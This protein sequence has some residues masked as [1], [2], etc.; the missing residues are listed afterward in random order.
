LL[1]HSLPL[2]TPPPQ[3]LVTLPAM[4]ASAGSIPCCS[5]ALGQ[6][7]QADLILK[8][9]RRVQDTDP[10]QV[11]CQLALPLD[12]PSTPEDDSACSHSSAVFAEQKAGQ[13]KLS[14]LFT[15]D[16]KELESLDIDEAQQAL[17]KPEA[18]PTHHFRSGAV[19][20][21]QWRG[22][23]RHGFGI[24]SW[25]DG[26]R[27]EGEWVDNMA[28]GR[29]RITFANGDVY[30]G[31]WHCGSFHGMGTYRASDGTKYVGEWSEDQR[32]GH[33][34][35]ITREGVK[36][37]GHFSAGYKEGRGICLW[38]DG[39][40]YCGNWSADMINGLGVHRNARG[41]VFRGRWLHAARHGIGCHVWND[42]RCYMGTYENNRE[43]GFGCYLNE[44]GVECTV[45]YW[46]GGLF[47]RQ[48][49]LTTDLHL[50]PA[51]VHLA[52][53]QPEPTTPGSDEV[54]LKRS[55]SWS[56]DGTLEMRSSGDKREKRRVSFGFVDKF[57][58]A[59]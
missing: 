17:E 52:A 43:A 12:N 8:I 23:A 28:E 41:G 3:A 54:V 20:T 51:L 5:T 32:H 55:Y 47:L 13:W 53:L 18:R 22:K 45:G 14:R 39:G 9:R 7:K 36:Y 2:P 50:Q 4:G 21:G 6:D 40:Q 33:G 57:P 27:Y 38:P 26:T 29:G 59:A 34:M 1:S 11:A 30:T 19:Y 56:S 37:A 15:L 16:I 49:P 35:E 24:Q 46:H 44:D 31:E 42:G 10:V 48:S 25:L 58:Y